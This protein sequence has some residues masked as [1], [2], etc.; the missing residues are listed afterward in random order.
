MFLL[1]SKPTV[2]TSAAAIDNASI[3]VQLRGNDRL[4]T[5]HPLTVTLQ[6]SA[7]DP[8]VRSISG[9]PARHLHRHVACALALPC[10][11]YWM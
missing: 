1:R 3:D 2:P 8:R 11:L 6:Y 10:P 4:R 9:S 7:I 5:R